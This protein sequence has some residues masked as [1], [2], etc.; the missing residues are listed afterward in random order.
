M[1]MRKFWPK[2]SPPTPIALSRHT[3]KEALWYEDPDYVIEKKNRLHPTIHKYLKVESKIPNAVKPNALNTSVSLIDTKPVR[4][5]IN[6][7]ALSVYKTLPL[8][9]RP[10]IAGFS[11]RVGLVGFKSGMMSYFDH[12]TGKK[13]AVTVIR[14]EHVQSLRIT[15]VGARRDRGLFSIDVGAG[16]QDPG[17]M[18]ACRRSYYARFGVPFKRVHMCF[19]ITK[20]AT[21]PP[22]TNL[23]AAHFVPGQ[24][25]DVRS[26]SI[27]KGFQGPMKRWGFKGLPASHGVSLAHRSHGATGMRQDPG[28][29]LPGKKMAGRMG[30]KFKSVLRLPVLKVDTKYNCIYVRGSIPGHDDCIVRVKDSLKNP[31]F[32]KSPPP[33]PTFIAPQNQNVPQV[34]V[35]EPAFYHDKKTP[36]KPHELIKL[37]K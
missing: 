25:V 8:Q 36:I 1:L 28:R 3:K 24:L 29:V 7:D 9:Q 17:N 20:D 11:K 37:L 33:F 21:I 27:G 23:F 26:K 5:V 2:A 35:A 14:F 31:T 6:S 19:S 16:S 34:M 32:A 18:S 22:G 4:D 15:S 12:V 13:H 30:G 10:Y